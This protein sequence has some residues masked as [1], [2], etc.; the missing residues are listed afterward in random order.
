M[1]WIRTPASRVEPLGRA[2]EAPVFLDIL[3]NAL[4]EYETKCQPS[5]RPQ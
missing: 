4:R 1:V 2:F 3:Q 5:H